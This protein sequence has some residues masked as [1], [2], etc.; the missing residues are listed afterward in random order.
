MTVSASAAIHRYRIVCN[1]D[2]QAED[3]HNEE[4][5]GSRCTGRGF[6]CKYQR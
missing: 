4:H 6:E 1:S 5:D 3:S 2:E